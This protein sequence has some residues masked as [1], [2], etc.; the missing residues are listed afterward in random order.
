MHV[1]AGLQFHFSFSSR[2]D[3]LWFKN[4]KHSQTSSYLSSAC[5]SRATPHLHSQQSVSEILREERIHKTGP[6]HSSTTR[7]S[8]ISVEQMMTACVLCSL[9]LQVNAF[10]VL[11]FRTFAFSSP[12]SPSC[13]LLGTLKTFLPYKKIKHSSSTLSFS[14]LCCAFFFTPRVH[15]NIIPTT[16][17]HFE[18]PLNSLANCNILPPLK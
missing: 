6:S 8:S 15:K 17:S 10:P 3:L 1:H 5:S 11:L 14:I 16:F 12:A 18:L 2:C 9:S 4:F 13:W 7:H